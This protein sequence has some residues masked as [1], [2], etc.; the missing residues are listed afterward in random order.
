M[1]AAARPR[2]VRRRRQ[3]RLFLAVAANLEGSG[4]KHVMVTVCRPAAWLKDTRTFSPLSKHLPYKAEKSAAETSGSG[5][6]Q[7]GSPTLVPTPPLTTL[8]HVGE[9]R[10]VGGGEGFACWGL[11][12]PAGSPATP[13]EGEAEWHGTRRGDGPAAVLHP[14]TPEGG[15][16]AVGGTGNSVE[17]GGPT[18]TGVSSETTGVS[19]YITVLYYC[20]ILY[21]VLNTPNGLYLCYPLQKTKPLFHI[22]NLF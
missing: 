1:V 11:A 16:V 6:E 20:I 10:E 2:L 5:L 3:R 22:Y 15:G 18:T 9:T 4:K 19:C 17:G 13:E 14:P 21:N 8:A 7:A 12:C